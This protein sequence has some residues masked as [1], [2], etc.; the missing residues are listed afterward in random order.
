MIWLFNNSIR[1]HSLLKHIARPH[2]HK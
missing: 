2:D 1:E